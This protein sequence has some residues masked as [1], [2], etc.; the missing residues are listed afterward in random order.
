M[1]I[2]KAQEQDI[3]AVAEIYEHIHDCEE[4]GKMTIGWLRGIYPTRKT[5]EEA[6]SLGDLFVLEDGGS[7]L[8]AGRINRQQLEE[9]ALARWSI[10]APAD[11]IMVLHTLVVEP[12][13]NGKGYARAFLDFYEKYSLEQ[14]C[15][16]LRID[17][18]AQNTAAR[19]MYAKHGWRE[20]DIVSCQ[21]FN[22][23][24]DIQLVCLEKTL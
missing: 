17:T 13:A 4:A 19:S 6:L 15:R 7:I 22:S 12:A 5:A 23:V 14:G 24:K 16:Y 11:E 21:A 9:Y 18:Q 2:R 3:N 8:A 1:N 10:D 20:A